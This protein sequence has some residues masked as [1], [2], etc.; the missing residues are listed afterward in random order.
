MR[1]TNTEKGIALIM[2]L[3]VT[4]IL[5]IFGML[6]LRSSSIQ[7]QQTEQSKRKER[8]LF[9]AEA[10]IEEAR[11]YILERGS[12]WLNSKAPNVDGQFHLGFDHAIDSTNGN[13][14]V[15]VKNTND[16]AGQ[17][18]YTISSVGTYFSGGKTI[19][20][21]IVAT[22]AAVQ[23][24]SMS[25]IFLFIGNDDQNVDNSYNVFGPMHINGDMRFNNTGALFHDKVTVTGNYRKNSG[26]AILTAGA[27]GTVVTGG[28]GVFDDINPADGIVDIPPLDNQEQINPIASNFD[29]SRYRAISGGIHSPGDLIVDFFEEDSPGLGGYVILN[30]DPAQ[31]YYLNELSQKTIYSDTDCYVQGTLQGQVVVAAANNIYTQGNILYSQLEP[32]LNEPHMMGL[33]AKNNIVIP[34][35]INSTLDFINEQGQGTPTSP[36]ADGIT[37]DLIISAALYAG[38]QVY[39]NY[40]ASEKK[41][42]LVINGSMASNLHVYFKTVGGGTYKG[43]KERFYN[44]DNSFNLFSPPNFISYSPPCLWNWHEEGI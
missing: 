7:Y 24:S 35:D 42:T 9:Y 25:D 39:F 41:G 19:Q 6:L 26:G 8:A 44:Y 22:A 20:R 16:I 37:G 13:I 5:T 18:L 34:E 28:W 3:S 4:G 10:G 17:D 27:T 32:P 12:N 38:N 30:N 1:N 43:F 23:Q 14:R 21:K 29:Q 33:M 40:G 31:K 11:W 15:E 2:V 36:Q